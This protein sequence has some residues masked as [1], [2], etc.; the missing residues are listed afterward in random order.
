M[1]CPNCG[2]ECY[3]DQWNR[4]PGP[5]ATYSFGPWTCAECG[6]FDGWTPEW[7][8]EHDHD[9]KYD[10]GIVQDGPAE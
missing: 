7:Q 9:Q 3:R 8:D 1:N 2:E 10:T 4:E 6:W 5:C